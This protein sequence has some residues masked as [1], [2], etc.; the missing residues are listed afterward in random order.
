M[1]PDASSKPLRGGLLT[2]APSFV[3]FNC[4]NSLYQHWQSELLIYTASKISQPGRIVRLLSTRDKPRS[5]MG[6]CETFVVPPHSP[7]PK[8]RD[9]YSPYNKPN[10]IKKWLDKQSGEDCV[11]LI[12]DPD[13][14]F[15]RPVT[16]SIKKGNPVSQ[17]VGYMRTNVPNAQAI[18]TRF[19]KRGFKLIDAV[20]IP[21]L[22]W[23]S[24]L[25]LMIDR[26]LEITENIRSDK[27]MKAKAGWVAEMW[28]Y[29]IAAAEAG[30]SHKIE[31][32]CHVPTEDKSTAPLIHYCFSSENKAKGYKWDKRTYK[33]WDRVI[34]PPPGTPKSAVVLATLV[35]ELASINGY[36]RI[37]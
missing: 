5:L 8:T 37:H 30:L 33:P 3:L 36:K 7:H 31:N 4:E 17:D 24:D 23:K 29:T 11:L 35:N 2:Q 10:S 25:E 9:D 21:T 28:G 22:I 26:W 16:Q 19:C 34:L 1:N 13:C 27:E 32:L 14:V 6:D 12:I 18:I 20:G 15:L